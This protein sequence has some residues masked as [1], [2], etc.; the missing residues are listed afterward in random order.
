MDHKYLLLMP[1]FLLC[2]HARVLQGRVHVGLKDLFT[3]SSG[4]RVAQEVSLH[5]YV[6]RSV[7]GYHGEANLFPVL[8]H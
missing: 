2:L 1:W 4:A 6:V 3:D 7:G 8:A 5:R